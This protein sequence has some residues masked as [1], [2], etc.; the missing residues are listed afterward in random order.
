MFNSLVSKLLWWES[1]KNNGWNKTIKFYLRKKNQSHINKH[2]LQQTAAERLSSHGLSL[3]LSQQKVFARQSHS[4]LTKYQDTLIALGKKNLKHEFN[5]LGSGWVCVNH[6]PLSI[7]RSSVDFSASCDGESDNRGYQKINWHKDFISGYSWCNQKLFDQMAVGSHKGADIKWP[8]E[9]GR[10]YHFADLAHLYLLTKEERYFDEI[11]KQFYDFTSSNP[12]FYGPQWGNAMEVSIRAINWIYALDQVY[13][14]KITKE[15]QFFQDIAHS[16]AEHLDYILTQ[17]EWTTIARSNHYLANLCG[18]AY[19]L[20]RLELTEASQNL[21]RWVFQE[22]CQE[23]LYQFLPDGGNYEGSIG[24]HRLS[25]EISFLTQNLFDLNRPEVSDQ[26]YNKFV[27]TNPFGLP[28]FHRQS[29]IKPFKTI[30]RL[31]L[32]HD[33]LSKVVSLSGEFVQVGDMD[34]GRV[35]KLTPQWSKNLEK[36]DHLQVESVRALRLPESC[37]LESYLFTKLK[38]LE[39]LSS[40]QLKIKNINPEIFFKLE[41]P[42]ANS[43]QSYSWSTTFDLQKNIQFYTFQN[44]GLYIVR[45]DHFYLSI[46]CGG[47]GAQGGVGGH[48]HND[49]LSIYLEIDQ[50]KLIV[51]PGSYA[52]TSYPKLRNEYRSVRAHFCPTVSGREPSSLGDGLFCLK[53][54]YEAVCE[55]FDGFQFLGWHSAYGKKTYRSI[56]VKKHSLQVNDYFF[57]N[58]PLDRLKLDQG[59][60]CSTVRPT[61]GYGEI[62]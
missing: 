37:Y 19:I 51:D 12:V 3:K 5:L 50:K 21:L 24:Y 17:L 44:F 8:W 36:E 39:K 62:S 58:L 34:S 35:L 2:I 42:L 61:R 59:F 23:V 14:Q 13:D 31:T 16:L 43:S 33:F 25:S 18:L 6:S 10:C 32:A 30:E 60:F 29:A 26:T 49:Q 56:H 20:S 48:S 45:S 9:L 57:G 54:N 41:T 40:R 4:I 27:K 15:A 55:Y 47:L 22:H 7:S 38:P 53:Q 11:K 28:F 46:R 1:V 52:Y